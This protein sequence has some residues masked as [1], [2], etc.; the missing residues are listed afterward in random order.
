MIEA[1]LDR[2]QGSPA[3][4]HPVDTQSETEG[5]EPSP[6][7]VQMLASLASLQPVFLPVQRGL[8]RG[9]ASGLHP[10]RHGA[11]ASLRVG[12]CQ[13]LDRIVAVEAAVA[14]HCRSERSIAEP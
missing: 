8:F 6:K 7:S 10:Y 2:K 4:S 14:R 5:S 9:F 1:S 11:L 3:H 12:G 13:V